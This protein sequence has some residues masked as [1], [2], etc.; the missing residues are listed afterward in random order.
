[1]LMMNGQQVELS[2]GRLARK[3]PASVAAEND[4]YGWRDDWGQHRTFKPEEGELTEAEKGE[5]AY[6]VCGANARVA[7]LVGAVRALHQAGVAGEW[8]RAA[9]AAHLVGFKS[10]F[11]HTGGGMVAP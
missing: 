1:M 10:Q 9:R 7:R 8:E 2:T 5:A 6:T 3:V 4:P 11:T